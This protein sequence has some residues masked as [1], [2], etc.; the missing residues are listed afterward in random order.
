MTG[1]QHAFPRLNFACELDTQQLE[2]VFATGA[3]DSLRETNAAVTLSLT[4]FSPERANVVRRLNQSGIPVTAWMA[5]PK[6]QGYYLNA[7]NAR[8]A[9]AR[10]TAFEKWT[11]VNDLRWAG[12]GLDIEPTVQDFE[13]LLQGHWLRFAGAIARRC[14]DAGRVQRAR[15][16]YRTLIKRMQ[17]D[18]YRV[19]TYQFP[20]L[21]D[22]RKVHSELLE[23]LFG[24]VDVRGDREVFMTYSSF[25][26]A[27]DSALVWEYAPEAQLVA[28]GSTAGDPKP[29]GKFIPM[30]W[31]EF[32]HD[33]IVAGHFFPV[34]GVYS[35]EGCIRQGFLPRLKTIDW[36]QTVTVPASSLQK[37]LGLRARIQSI[38]WTA[39][40][41]P[42][43]AGVLIL[44]DVWLIRRRRGRFGP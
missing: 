12:V 3:I 35:L 23:R 29:G 19:D 6:E 44:L 20:F 18:G 10:F 5:L 39:S 34:V 15:N 22:A 24:I 43:I 41:L 17:T 16:A 27:V 30:N 36:S 1:A 11:A 28:V 14:F 25:N 38:L 21:A 2:S 7:G 13:L 9:S 32:T 37:V 42:Y 40:R 33:A 8:E 31:D 4:D 26:H